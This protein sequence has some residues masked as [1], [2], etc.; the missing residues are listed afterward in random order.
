VIDQYRPW[1]AGVRLHKTRKELADGIIVRSD[2]TLLHVPP[3]VSHR[4]PRLEAYRWWCEDD[5]CDCT[6]YK[7]DRITFP[8][9]GRGW[10]KIENL[11]EGRFVTDTSEE[12]RHDRAKR[13]SAFRSAAHELGVG[14]ERRDWTQSWHGRKEL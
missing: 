11:W 7:I 10:A 6:Q 3:K 8:D 5:I 1:W 4:Q 13:L 14:L 12:S 2:E 9:K